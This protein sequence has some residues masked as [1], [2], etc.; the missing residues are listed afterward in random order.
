MKIY[1][2]FFSCLN[3]GY[4]DFLVGGNMELQFKKCMTSIIL[5]KM[6][7]FTKEIRLGFLKD[8]WKAQGF[9]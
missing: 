5:K 2:Y 6:P 1:M 8:K 3:L 9:C 4:N 7:L